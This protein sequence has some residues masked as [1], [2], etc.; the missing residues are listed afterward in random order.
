MVGT[1]KV[2]KIPQYSFQFKLIHGA[3]LRSQ[4]LNIL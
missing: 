4:N 1:Q 3:I 2:L